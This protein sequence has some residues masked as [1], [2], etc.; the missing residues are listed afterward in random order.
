MIMQLVVIAIVAFIAYWWASQ[1]ALSALLHLACV[2]AAGAVAFGVW[3]LAAIKG[4]FPLN[5]F[6]HSNAWTIGLLLPFAICLTIFRVVTDKIVGANLALHPNVNWI[7]GG[8]FGLGAGVITTGIIVIGI[9]YLQISPKLFGYQAYAQDSTNGT[10][11]RQT[12]LWLPVDTLTESFYEGLSN[13]AF[14]ATTPLD[15]YRPNVA[16]Q[17]SLLRINFDEGKSRNTMQPGDATVARVLEVQGDAQ[18]IYDFGSVQRGWT[19]SDPFN[20]RIASGTGYIVVVNFT[21]SARERTGSMAVGNA[22]FQLVGQN[23]DGD[24][25]TVFP[26][27]VISQADAPGSPLGRF[28]FDSKDFFVA[29]VPG[30]SRPTMAF[31]FVLPQGYE[32]RY[33]MARGLRLDLPAGQPE[34][35]TVAQRNR[36]IA[37]NNLVSAGGQRY[38]REGDFQTRNAQRLTLSGRSGV[39]RVDST[40]PNH[41]TLAKDQLSS[42]RVND[43][44]EVDGGKQAFNVALLKEFKP[45]GVA[46]NSFFRSAGEQIV[47]ATVT[48]HPA[49][50]PP[51]QNPGAV[52][53]PLLIDSEGNQYVAI[54]YVFTEREQAEFRYDIG[55]PILNLGALPSSLSAQRTD[56]ELVLLF[57]VRDG[58]SLERFSYGPDVRAEFQ[59]RV[60][61]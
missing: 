13:G 55:D 18:E 12:S 23:D 20:G 37:S 56:Q 28:R 40:L 54:G 31:E 3:E 61:R 36:G 33:M 42:L 57:S 34:T 17:A 47:Q 9:G 60:G 1:G 41:W 26:I 7:V 39:I 32:P 52:Q 51:S 2:V 46:I 8:V 35:M 30:E 49:L 38:V 44:R 15:V 19:Y 50:K 59:L 10:I 24:V 14:S 25:T 5:E 43:D 27:A 16:A 22:Q 21:A 58:I 4:L 53:T 29:S 6:F 48:G 45:R 11:V